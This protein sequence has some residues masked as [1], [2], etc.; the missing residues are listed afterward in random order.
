VSALVEEAIRRQLEQT[1]RLQAWDEYMEAYEAE[2]GAF[3]PGEA[4]RLAREFRAGAKTAAQILA[5]E[6]AASS[7]GDASPDTKAA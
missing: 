4:E 7:T 5:E 2:F 6:A 1:Q 3:E